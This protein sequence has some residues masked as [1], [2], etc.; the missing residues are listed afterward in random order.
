MFLLPA[1]TV[2]ILF[3]VVSVVWAGF[4]SFFNWSGVG[5]KTFIG[6]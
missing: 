1:L 2:Y 3:V 4:Y 5:E 6:I